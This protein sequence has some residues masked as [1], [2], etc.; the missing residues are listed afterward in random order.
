MRVVSYCYSTELPIARLSAIEAKDVIHITLRWCVQGWVWQTRGRGAVWWISRSS[1]WPGLPHVTIPVSAADPVSWSANLW[2][3]CAPQLCSVWEGNKSAGNYVI[4]CLVPHVSSAQLTVEY[5]CVKCK[6]W[7][8]F[9]EIEETCTSEILLELRKITPENLTN[10]DNEGEQAL[11]KEFVKEKL[12]E[13]YYSN[14]R[15]KFM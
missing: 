4:R 3:G 1:S 7:H 11:L 12:D 9:L 15:L 8:R 10:L 6:P 5:T 2:L 13:D 14:T